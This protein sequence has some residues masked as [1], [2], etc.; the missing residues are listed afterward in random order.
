M[1]VLLWVDDITCGVSWFLGHMGPGGAHVWPPE[2]YLFEVS[3]EPA[4]SVDPGLDLSYL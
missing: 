2:L 1:G 3:I 4:Q